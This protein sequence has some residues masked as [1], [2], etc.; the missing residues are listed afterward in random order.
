[1]ADEGMEN[2]LEMKVADESLE[3]LKPDAE[4]SLSNDPD[5][6]IK[7]SRS[8]VE[9]IAALNKPAVVEQPNEEKVQADL[10]IL[11]EK[12]AQCDKRLVSLQ[13]SLLL[14]L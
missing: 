9:R 8:F 7:D 5:N 12:I 14:G 1:M 6:K 3:L 11:K 2:P 13:R 4:K 10:A